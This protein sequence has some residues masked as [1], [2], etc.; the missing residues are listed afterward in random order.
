MKQCE[1]IINGDAKSLQNEVKK[2]AAVKTPIKK[3]NIMKRK[4]HSVHCFPSV[5]IHLGTLR[6]T[7]CI[8]YKIVHLLLLLLLH[9]WIANTTRS[10]HGSAT[11]WEFQILAHTKKRRDIFAWR[12]TAYTKREL[13]ECKVR[14][15]RLWQRSTLQHHQSTAADGADSFTNQVQT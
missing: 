6:E 2:P 14:Q 4:L 9:V 8:A 1:I 10:R 13:F 5:W 11:S 3:W 12:L 15:H 7:R